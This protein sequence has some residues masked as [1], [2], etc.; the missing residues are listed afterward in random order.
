[1]PTPKCEL[2]PLYPRPTECEG[3]V[4]VAEFLDNRRRQQADELGVEISTRARQRA[5]ERREAIAACWA[6]NAEGRWPNGVVCP[7]DDRKML[8][9]KKGIE[10]VREALRKAQRGE[11]DGQ[12]DEGSR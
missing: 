5:E 4:R 3:C 1:M 6:C 12:S 10:K 8:A 2:H 9:G 11:R 7:H